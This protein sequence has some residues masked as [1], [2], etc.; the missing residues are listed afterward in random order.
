MYESL[1]PTLIALMTVLPTLLAAPI[2][3]YWAVEQD[4]R[5]ARPLE[6][7]AVAGLGVAAAASTYI[8]LSYPMRTLIYSYPWISV[9][10]IFTTYVSFVVDFLSRYMGLLTAWLAFAIGVYSLEYMADDYRLGWFWFFYNTFAASM[11]LLVYSNNLLL[12]FIGWEGL[13]LSSWALIG[14]WFR[15]DDE[16]SFVGK[17][18]DT[19]MGKPAWTTPSYA[20]YRAIVTIRFGDMPMLGALAAIGIFG[21][22]LDFNSI[23]WAHLTSSLGAVGTA[24]VLIAFLL[25]PFTKSAQF[26]FNDWLL[27]AMTGP[28]SVSALLH[29]ATMVA[30]GVY[31]FMRLTLYLVGINYVA[32][33]M[34]YLFVLYL[35]LVTAILGAMFATSVSERKVILAG[36]TMSSLGLMM[37]LTAASKFI[38]ISVDALGYMLPI[39]VLVGFSYLIVHALSKASLF[40]VSGHLIHETHTRFNLGNWRLAERLP[41]GFYSTLAAAVA[42]GGIPPFAAYWVHSA[43]D[44]LMIDAGPMV[45]WGAYALLLLTSFVY[46][47]FL[48][49]FMSLN[50]IKGD[51]P[52]EVEGHGGSVMAG[53]YTATATAALLVAVPVLMMSSP[54]VM[55]IA[56]FDPVVFL[57]S[58][59]ITITFLVVAYKPRS[60]S[61]A[62][63]S[64]VFERRYYIQAFMDVVLAGFGRALTGFAMLFS[65]GFD[66][67]FNN[68]VPRLFKATS[69]TIRGVQNGLVRSYAKAMLI[70]MTIILFIIMMVMIYV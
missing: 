34:V 33:N 50:F 12:M 35:G 65:R 63:A 56:G 26:P 67:L 57:I 45:G 30:A 66:W 6:Y 29:S 37:A 2:S 27:T 40:L 11:L 21:G 20:A 41:A 53:A 69:D 68:A 23:N 44:E 19:V 38:P 14:N 49:R 22:S 13:G 43:M 64:P 5:K 8:A 3:V 61:F 52:G 7:L 60:A 47:M 42:L 51:D 54:N 18:G 16:T 32:I 15:D 48:A 4:N 1:L 28:T 9:P 39:G 55:L 31:I 25:G 58:L 36:S 24:V 59:A 62:L 70:V 10:G 46:V 17:V